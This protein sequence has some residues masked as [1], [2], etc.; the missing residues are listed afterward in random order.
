MF[1]QANI[2]NIKDIYTNILIIEMGIY[3]KI[4]IK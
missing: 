4:N 1:C 2:K 3:L